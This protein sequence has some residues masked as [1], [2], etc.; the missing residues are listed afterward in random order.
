M[1]LKVRFNFADQAI[2][3]LI[4]E[5]CDG[6]LDTLWALVGDD[7]LLTLFSHIILYNMDILNLT[8]KS[9]S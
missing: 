4:I 7:N 1:S 5:P 8:Y 6:L 2:Y 3:S 9:K